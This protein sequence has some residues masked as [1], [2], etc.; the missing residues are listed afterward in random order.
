M[1]EAALA[2]PVERVP[3]AATWAGHHWYIGLG[4]ATLAAWHVADNHPFREPTWTVAGSVT[5]FIAFMLWTH[6]PIAGAVMSHV[7]LGMILLE[8]LSPIG[9]WSRYNWARVYWLDVE[10]PL[11]GW[12]L[13]LPYW[14]RYR[15][16]ALIGAY[17]AADDL[18]S[19]AWGV[20]TVLD[21]LVWGKWIFPTLVELRALFS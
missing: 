2:W 10:L 16:W 18:A 9:F 17:I 8:L 3:D 13:G 15:G 11:V 6:H 19:H 14:L 7:G 20:W 1:I 12:R 21:G 5:G 4:L